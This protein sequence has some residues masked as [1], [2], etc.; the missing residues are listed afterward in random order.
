[1]T[2]DKSVV[3]KKIDDARGSCEVWDLENAA[4]DFELRTGFPARDAAV[5]LLMGA[6]RAAS[7]RRSQEAVEFIN[8]LLVPVLHTNRYPYALVFLD[9][10]ETAGLRAQMAS[11]K[12]PASGSEAAP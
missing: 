6:A 10:G 7:A 8:G 2:T 4:D 9:D 1:M 3:T 5:V 12:E 11:K